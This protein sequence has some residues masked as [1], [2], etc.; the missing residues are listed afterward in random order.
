[1]TFQPSVHLL[2]IALKGAYL[3]L[4]PDDFRNS[5]KQSDNHSVGAD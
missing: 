3:P 1:M 4:I 5:K 2:G